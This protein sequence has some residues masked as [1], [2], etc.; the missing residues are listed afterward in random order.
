ML[1]NGII[2]IVEKW[3][4][5]VKTQKRKIEVCPGMKVK[6]RFKGVQAETPTQLKKL[7]YLAAVCE[8]GPIKLFKLD[9]SKYVKVN[10][11][12]VER[13]GRVD[14]EFLLPFWEKIHEAAEELLGEGDI[15]IVL[16][17]A[18]CHTSNLTILTLESIFDNVIIQPP[19]SPD[20][21]LLDAYVFPQLEKKCNEQGALSHD[22]ID[23]SVKKAWKTVTHESLQKAV[24]RVKKNMKECIAQKGG[25][26]YCEGN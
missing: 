4:T 10:K 11:N 17:R 13:P 3:F 9:W 12:G 26:F 25:N 1:K 14:S 19:K 2:H 8:S 5:E 23:R 6:A 18:S 21:S 24:K 7:M 22:E 20:F 16:D 15:N